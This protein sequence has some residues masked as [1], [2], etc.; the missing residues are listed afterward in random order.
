[1]E[2]DPF[3][4]ARVA[5]SVELMGVKH[6]VITSVDRDDLK[7]MAGANIWASTIR[8]VRRRSPQTKLET[9]IPD[10]KGEWVN[11]DRAGGQA[12]SAQP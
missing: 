4:P 5:R 11:L 6:C 8:A 1:L 9:F 3:E 10:F 12:R 7:S 2:A